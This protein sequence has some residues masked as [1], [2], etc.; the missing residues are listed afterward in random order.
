[1][2]ATEHKRTS[3]LHL[4]IFVIIA[5]A[6]TTQCRPQKTVPEGL[7]GTWRTNAAKYEGCYFEISD[8]HVR[9]G[10]REGRVDGGEIKGV[11]ERAESGVPLY[12]I[13]Y[14]GDGE[15]E[16]LLEFYYDRDDDVIRLR[17]QM[18]IVWTKKTKELNSEIQ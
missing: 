3:R 11:G 14:A 6:G 13:R 2:N 9:I 7:M 16:N 1:M 18:D 15:P 8:S 17:N 12:T 10:T 4:I 5:I